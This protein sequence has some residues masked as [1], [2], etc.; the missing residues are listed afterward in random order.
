[1]IGQALYYRECI[2][3]KLNVPKVR[4]FIIAREITSEVRIAS[5]AVPDVELFEFKLSMTLSKL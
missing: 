5:K 1:M 4:T 2:K 3:E